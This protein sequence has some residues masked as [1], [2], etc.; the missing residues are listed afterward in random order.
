MKVMVINPILIML[1]LLVLP[2]FFFSFEEISTT[3]DVEVDKVLQVLD[4]KELTLESSKMHAHFI[5]VNC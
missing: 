3:L 4:T 2:M 1:L 5:N